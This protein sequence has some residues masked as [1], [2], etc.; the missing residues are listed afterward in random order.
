MAP[1]S[2]TTQGNHGSVF[3]VEVTHMVLPT[4]LYY[5]YV[6]PSTPYKDRAILKKCAGSTQFYVGERV[7]IDSVFLQNY[8][9][10]NIICLADLSTLVLGF[11]LVEMEDLWFR[12]DASKENLLHYFHV[13][14]VWDA[15]MSTIKCPS[16]RLNS[17]LHVLINYCLRN[18]PDG[19]EIN[20]HF[21]SPAKVP[22]KTLCDFTCQWIQ[23]STESHQNQLGRYLPL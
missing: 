3:K 2:S 10:L 13:W 7:E 4:E 11:S 12:D 21:S 17:W 14:W 18:S 5:D 8:Y 22:W 9:G 20:Y 1:S 16:A 19:N 15:Q 23:P 6:W